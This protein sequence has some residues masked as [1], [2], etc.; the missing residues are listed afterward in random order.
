MRRGI[1]SP[2]DLGTNKQNESAAKIAET[3]FFVKLSPLTKDTRKNPVSRHNQNSS[4]FISVHPP[5]SAIQKPG[6]SPPRTSMRKK[7]AI[8]R[9][10]QMSFSDNK[11]IERTIPNPKSS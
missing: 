5:S 9:P 2:A 6:F 7:L 10:K 11:L 4:A 8:A 1:D 3:G